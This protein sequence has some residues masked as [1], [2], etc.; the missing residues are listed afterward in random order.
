MMRYLGGLFACLLLV[1]PSFAQQLTPTPSPLPSAARLT[2]L[3]MIW[4][5]LNRCS[6]AAFTILMSYFEEF[7]GDYDA[8]LRRLNPHLED[9]SVRIEEMIIAAS[10]YGLRGIARRGG[11]LELM[12]AL[13]ANGF[14]VLLENS[15]YDGP[16]GY[17]DWMSHNRILIGYDDSTQELLFMDSL[18]GSGDGTGRRFKYDDI[19]SRWQAFNYDYLIIYRPADEEKL[20]L[21]LGDQWDPIKNAEW[22]LE[23]AERDIA[24]SRNSFNVYNKGWALTQLG[25]YAEAVE[26]F[27]LARSISLPV[28]F[29]WYEFTA[30]DAYLAVGRYDDV[31]LI[32]R[33]V[34]EAAPGIEE[35]YYYIALA[36][37]GTGNQ[38]RAIANLKAALFRNSFYVEAQTKLAELEGTGG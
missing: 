29:F 17:K 7:T 16:N 15:Y 35:M 27:D 20:K 8:N 4:Q 11:T 5:D 18:L 1:A 2:G 32:T 36:Y 26:A 14:P 22:T 28:R 19:V 30:L 12:K 23:L 24:V 13:V 33:T 25:R 3:D 38:D 6:A 10:E 9:M 31:F 37:L 34:I 21:I